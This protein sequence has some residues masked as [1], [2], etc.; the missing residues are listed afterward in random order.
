MNLKGT[1]FFKSLFSLPN[2]VTAASWPLIFRSLFSYPR[3]PIN[4]VTMD[5]NLISTPVDYLPR[6]V[7]Y[8]RLIVSL[9]QLSMWYGQT[10]I[11]FA[12]GGVVSIDENLF[13]MQAR[14]DNGAT[15]SGSPLQKS[16]CR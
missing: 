10:T 4:L 5:W 7:C 16:P 12:R 8:S 15:D 11:V 9:V 3:G 6:H 2:V 1:G 14:W 13:R